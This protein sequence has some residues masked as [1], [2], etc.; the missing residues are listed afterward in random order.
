MGLLKHKI[1]LF[2]YVAIALLLIWIIVLLS[3]PNTVPVHLYYLPIILAAWY[4]KVPGGIIVGFVCGILAGPLMLLNVSENINQLTSNWLI[5]LGFFMIYGT[6]LGYLFNKLRIQTEQLVI[7]DKLIKEQ[8]Y[9]AY[10]DPLTEISNRR[11]F[12]SYLHDISLFASRNHSPYSLIILD[13]DHFKFFNDTYGHQKGDDCLKTI[14]KAV[15]SVLKRPT[16]L[17]ARYGGEEFVIL[18]PDTNL[19]EATRMAETIRQVIEELEL[20]NKHS[21]VKPIVTVSFG[22]ATLRPQFNIKPSELI[23]LAD[24]ALYKAKTNGRNRVETYQEHL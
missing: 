11:H 24:Q 4:W 5:R 6:L 22:V 12:D 21:T 20:P 10:T 19:D 1:T 13:I 9:F 15:Q 16:D 14:V 7:Q 23:D 18:L 3:R 8:S 2:V 17:F